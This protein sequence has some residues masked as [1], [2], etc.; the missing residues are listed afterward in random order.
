VKLLLFL[1]LLLASY[2]AVC[3]AGRSIGLSVG[4]LAAGIILGAALNWWLRVDIVPLG[5][6]R[7]QL[8]LHTCFYS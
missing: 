4:A 6:S 2:A 3:L 5:V 7:Q 8:D 1:L